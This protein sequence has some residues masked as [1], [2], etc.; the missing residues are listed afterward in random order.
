MANNYFSFKEFTIQQSDCNMK[1][2]T[3]SC[4]FGAWVAQ[5]IYVNKKDEINVLDVGTGT[6]L[7]SLMISQ[8]NNSLNINAVEIHSPSAL[9]AEQN[10]LN[11]PWSRKIEIIEVGILDFKPTHKYDI[12]ITNPPFFAGSLKSPNENQNIPKHESDLT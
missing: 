11:S 2:C 9:Q 10:V 8:L 6:G 1:V 4:L 12:I 7:L 3:D 5:D